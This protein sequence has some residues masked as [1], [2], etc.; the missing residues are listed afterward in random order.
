MIFYVICRDIIFVLCVRYGRCCSKGIN[1]KRRAVSNVRRRRRGIVIRKVPLLCGWYMWGR[2]GDIPGRWGR[3]FI[4][5]KNGARVK[6][7]RT[8]IQMFCEGDMKRVKNARRD[9]VPE[10]VGFGVRML[11]SSS[12]RSQSRILVSKGYHARA[13]HVSVY[14]PCHVS[15]WTKSGNKPKERWFTRGIGQERL[16]VCNLVFGREDQA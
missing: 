4:H 13:S 15:K 8:G 6:Q 10:S 12:K 2:S 5:A 11:H 3:S 9:R 1:H 7:R 16:Q 14:P